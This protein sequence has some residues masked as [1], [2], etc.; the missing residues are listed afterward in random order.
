LKDSWVAR[1]T[2]VPSRSSGP[3]DGSAPDDLSSSPPPISEQPVRAVAIARAST[4]ARRARRCA[5]SISFRLPSPVLTGSGLEGLRRFRTL[6][7]PAVGG[8]PCLLLPA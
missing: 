5:K 1:T 4:L 7:S 2:V 6:S 8:L 3:A